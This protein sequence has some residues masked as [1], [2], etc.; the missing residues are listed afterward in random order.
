LSHWIDDA[1]DHNPIPIDANGAKSI[2]EIGIPVPP[3]ARA[4]RPPMEL[5]DGVI[6]SGGA[7]LTGGRQNVQWWR[8]SI[9]PAEA[10]KME[11]SLTRFVPGRVGHGLTDDL[12][13][14]TDAMLKSGKVAID[15]N[16]GLWYDRRRDDHQRVRR[17][18]GDVWPPFYEQPFARSGKDL[19]WDGLSKYDLAKYNA[20]YFDRLREFVRLGEEKG[21]VLLNHHYFQ[22]NILEAGAHWADSPWRSANNVNAT[23]FPEPPPYAGDKRIFLAEQFYDVTHPKRRELHRA[24]IRQCLANHADQLN[25]IHLTSAEFTGPLP[26]VQFW[27]DVASEWERETGKDA[28]IGLSATKDVQDAILEDSARARVVD[29]IDIRYWWY[30]KDGSLYAPEGGKNL[31]PRQHARQGKP[32]GSS[33]EMVERAVGEYRTKYPAKAVVYSADGFDRFGAAAARAG[34]SLAQVK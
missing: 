4:T 31:A 34:G 26:F 15:H 33:A 11:V 9:R 13:E 10:A 22:H 21:L 20:W 23:G 12:D 27:L 16:Y 8:G 18:S 5:K 25:V 30:R 32:G 7:P 1:A 14:L 28:L 6:V 29:V 17:M 19:A 24:F 2:D 3:A